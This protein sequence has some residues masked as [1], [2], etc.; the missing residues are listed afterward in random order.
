[1]LSETKQ[2]YMLYKQF[3]MW[4]QMNGIHNDW[5]IKVKFIKKKIIIIFKKSGLCLCTR[6][7]TINVWC[8]MQDHAVAVKQYLYGVQMVVWHN[9]V[10]HSGPHH[11]QMWL[12]WFKIYVKIL[13]Y[14]IFSHYIPWQN[15]NLLFK[16]R[17]SCHINYLD[18]HNIHVFNSI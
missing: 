6:P 14:L 3:I 5:A 12:W 18:N 7:L 10:E 16:S 8:V 4:C 13:N 15:Q 2:N 9:F 1:M 17:F 11:T